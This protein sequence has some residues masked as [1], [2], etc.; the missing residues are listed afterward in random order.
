MTI[1]Q[2][3]NCPSLSTHR[4]PPHPILQQARRIKIF[5]TSFDLSLILIPGV[6][7]SHGECLSTHRP[8]PHP[9]LQQAR[10][11][12]I[13]NTSFDFSLILIPGVHKSHGELSYT[14]KHIPYKGWGPRGKKAWPAT[15]PLFKARKQMLITHQYKDTKTVQ[16]SQ[17]LLFIG[18][19]NVFQHC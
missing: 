14:A 11:I 13:F 2:W 1:W 17:Q 7:K 3:L 12:K 9:I 18:S 6:H 10:R 15:H 5:N 8:P 16:H 4:P 19:R